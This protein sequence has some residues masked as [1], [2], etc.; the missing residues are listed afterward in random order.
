VKAPALVAVDQ[1]AAAFAT[2]FAAAAERGERLGWL[3]L[4]AADELP[5]PLAAAAAAGA[6]KAVAVSAGG[7]LAW[8][9]RRGAPVLRDLLREHFLGCLAVLVRGGAGWPRL[10]IA[11]PGFRFELGEGRAR[12]LA[13]P[14]L[15]AELARPRHRA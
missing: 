15:V 13:A 8:K 12:E 14:D 2:L 9:R 10:A 11:A 3:E 1:P 7:S 4:G 5:A 6:A